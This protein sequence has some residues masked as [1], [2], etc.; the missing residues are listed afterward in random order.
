MQFS[1]FFLI[2]YQNEIAII[3]SNVSNERL[4]SIIPLD[5]DISAHKHQFLVIP[6]KYISQDPKVIFWTA[7]TDDKYK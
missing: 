3:L 5:D 6:R 4:I 2:I 7:V 1:Y